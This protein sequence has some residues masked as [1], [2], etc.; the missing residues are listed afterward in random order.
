LVSCGREQRAG[1]FRSAF[2]GASIVA[3]LERQFQGSGV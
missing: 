1:A 2:S 3:A